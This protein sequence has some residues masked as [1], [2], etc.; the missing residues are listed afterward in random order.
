MRQSRVRRKARPNC[1]RRWRL[2]STKGITRQVTRPFV[3]SCVDRRLSGQKKSCSVALGA[4]LPLFRR[5]CLSR[6]SLLK[7]FTQ[8]FPMSKLFRRQWSHA[9]QPTAG[10]ARPRRTRGNIKCITRSR[11]RCLS[12]AHLRLPRLEINNATAVRVK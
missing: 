11:L 9:E 2:F 8:P 6:G 12:L 4:V 7:Q 5:N 1:L 3:G 10:S